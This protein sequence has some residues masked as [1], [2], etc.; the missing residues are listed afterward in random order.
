MTKTV[1]ITGISGQDG[2]YLA[3]LLLKK[4]YVVYGIVRRSSSTSTE[5]LPK[6]DNLILKYGDLNDIESI[7]SV[8]Q[9]IKPDELYNLASQSH[10]HVS[11]DLPISTMQTN[12][13][14]TLNMLEAI[15]KYSPHTKF[16]NA[17]TS[18]I[19]GKGRTHPL[20][21]KSPFHPK[22]P[23]GC[24]K[25]FAHCIT[26]NY[27][28]SY[29]LF[30]C[31]G[32]LFN[33]ESPRRGVSFV[34]RKITRAVAK[35]AL[36]EKKTLTLGNLDV[37]RDWGYAPEYVEAMWLMLQQD[38]PRDYVIATGE[39]HSIREFVEAS[40]GEIGIK[41]DWKGRGVQEKGYDAKTK[42][43]LVAI[44]PSFYRPTEIDALYGS[45]ERAKKYLDWQPKIKYKD[46]VKIMVAADVKELEE[47]KQ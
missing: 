31:N 47:G 15:R 7:S 11:F 19:F 27:R 4:G 41:L 34:T 22:N 3:E 40:F 13:L 16:Y 45:T 10:V 33:H 25:V 12:G 24:A 38:K 44:D 26:V 42:E 23:Y 2:G 6:N 39:T 18:E 32:I 9:Q 36:G 20:D 35:H 43:L 30:A 29:N 37:R 8:I 14:S 5:Y 1:L 17:S 46:L 21:E 28:E